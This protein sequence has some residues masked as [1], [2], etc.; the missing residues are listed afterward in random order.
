MF[1]FLLPGKAWGLDND[2]TKITPNRC[3]HKPT[4]DIK[5]CCLDFSIPKDAFCIVHLSVLM[6]HKLNHKSELK[7]R[8]RRQHHKILR[9]KVVFKSEAGFP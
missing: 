4:D 3:T 2:G 8:I 6:N 5:L 9:I 7:I 1:A